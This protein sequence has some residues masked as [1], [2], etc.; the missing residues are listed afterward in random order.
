MDSICKDY[1]LARPHLLL[2]IGLSLAVVL[3]PLGGCLAGL[4]ALAAGIAHVGRRFRARALRVP[5]GPASIGDEGPGLVLPRLPF[6]QEG[7]K[8]GLLLFWCLVM[9]LLLGPFVVVPALFSL[10]ALARV[11]EEEG[12]SAPHEGW[13]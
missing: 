4:V 7:V 6:T 8:T 2:G 1:I 3:G 10:P 13:S 11:A 5:S 12:L 9:A